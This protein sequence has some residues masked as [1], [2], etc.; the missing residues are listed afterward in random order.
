VNVTIEATTIEDERAVPLL[1]ALS[2]VL[3]AITGST[4]ESSF[5]SSDL[6]DAR[7]VFLLAQADGVA[8][9]CGAFRRVNSETCEIKRMYVSAG[10]KGIG[11]RLLSELER[12]AAELG[13]TRVILETRK[14]NAAAVSFY[15]KNAFLVIPNYGKY[16]GNELAIC[17][18]KRIGANR[19]INPAP[20]TVTPVAEQPPRRL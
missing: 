11:S 20:A 1:R 6:N 9:G 7:S 13:Y 17:F 14:I 2:G 3:G 19:S 12:R 18:E 8:H 15:L 10:R 5:S 16:V 4:G